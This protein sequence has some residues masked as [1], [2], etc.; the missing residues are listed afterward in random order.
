[1]N[2]LTPNAQE[3]QTRERCFMKVDLAT[4]QIFCADDRASDIDRYI[5]ILGGDLN[6]AF[7][8]ATL[9]HTLYPDQELPDFLSQVRSTSKLLVEG[10]HLRAGV[11]SA[12]ENEKTLTSSSDLE[13]PIGCGYAQNR[14]Y[15]S[16]VIGNP[17]SEVLA[18][19][20]SLRPE[21]FDDQIYRDFGQKI[22]ST[23]QSLI[24]KENGFF[25]G[26]FG[27]KVYQE[28]VQEGCLTMNVRGEHTADTGIIN[29]KN[30]T[31]ISTN[32]AL[33]QGLPAYD[34][35]AWAVYE[36]THRLQSY[37]EIDQKFI[38]IADL[39]DCIGTMQVLGV[40]NIEVRR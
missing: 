33:S 29:L 15:I 23:H 21:L 18:I 10:M 32:L 30:N 27:R 9:L 11:H 17:E 24:S 8:Y 26:Y 40:Q 22:I 25:K 28:A 16:Q 34:H 5:H 19:G 3:S 39:I 1:M 14:P 38:Q 36:I 35:D 31:S 4:D 37:F 20:Q 13:H 7:L 6:I 12:E 2:T